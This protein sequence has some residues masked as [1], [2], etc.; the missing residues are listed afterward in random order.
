MPVSR[1]RQAEFICMMFSSKKALI[2]FVEPSFVIMYKF[3]TSGRMLLAQISTV[4]NGVFSL[5][6]SC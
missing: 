4:H 3:Y 5:E 2:V 1:S 6:W